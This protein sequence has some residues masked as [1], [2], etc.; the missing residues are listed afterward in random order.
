VVDWRIDRPE[1]R[2]P[3]SFFDAPHYREPVARMIE[4]DVAEAIRR[5][6]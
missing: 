2:D 6:R 3:A 1:T 4:R 5:L